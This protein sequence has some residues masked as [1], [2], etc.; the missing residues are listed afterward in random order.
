MTTRLG[1]SLCAALIL[2]AAAASPVPAPT[3]TTIEV[4]NTGRPCGT[5]CRQDQRS[6]ACISEFRDSS[7][8]HNPPVKPHSAAPREFMARV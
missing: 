7:S 3:R 5:G 8:I 1:R 6:S 4:T 2:A